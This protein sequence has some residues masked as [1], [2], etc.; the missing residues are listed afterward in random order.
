MVQKKIAFAELPHE[1]SSN[2][3]WVLSHRESL[4]TN[5]RK[6]AIAAVLP[7]VLETAIL[8]NATLKIPYFANAEISINRWAWP[9]IFFHTL[10]AGYG[11]VLYSLWASHRPIYRK[12]YIHLY[13]A[14][15]ENRDHPAL[16]QFLQSHPYVVVAHNGDL[17]GKK[18]DP[19]LFGVSIGRRRIVTPLS[20]FSK[21]EVAGWWRRLPRRSR[22][23]ALM[24]K[25]GTL[26]DRVFGFH[27]Q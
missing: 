19:R 20:A 16:K 11:A 17:V 24:K 7:V 13:K 1:V 14:L 18:S 12:E 8:S 21:Y 10:V 15:R 22:F 27:R 3:K 25:A 4:R 5:T 9:A 6:H 26:V 23:V 2:V